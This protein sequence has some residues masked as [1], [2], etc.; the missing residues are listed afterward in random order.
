VAF[1]AKS[2]APARVEE[3]VRT[4]ERLEKLDDVRRLVG[5]LVP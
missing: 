1:A 4:V 2:P 3:I 5:L